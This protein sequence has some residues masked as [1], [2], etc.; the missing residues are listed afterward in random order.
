M[1][2][3]GI[4]FSTSKSYPCRVLPRCAAPLGLVGVFPTHPLLEQRIGIEPISSRWK[5]EAVPKLL[6]PQMV[7]SARIEQASTVLQTAAMT[8][9]A[10]SALEAEAGLAPTLF[11]V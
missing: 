8:T 10:N 1:K 2:F 6:T 3:A 9:S 11:R 4:D 7:P 5:R